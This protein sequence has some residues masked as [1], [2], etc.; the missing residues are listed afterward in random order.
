MDVPLC[1]P[2]AESQNSGDPS[3]VLAS[4]QVVMS[5]SGAMRTFRISFPMVFLWFFSKVLRFEDPLNGAGCYKY[6]NLS[7]LFTCFFLASGGQVGEGNSESVTTAAL[8]ALVSVTQMVTPSDVLLNA[9]NTLNTLNTL[10]RLA[11]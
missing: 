8:D 5:L 2:E 7:S 10:E 3:Q 9:L 4:V 1:L 11:H 6:I